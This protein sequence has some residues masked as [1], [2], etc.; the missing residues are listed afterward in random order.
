MKER[1]YSPID[2]GRLSLFRRLLLGWFDEHGRVLPW[3]DIKDPYKIWV[4]EII[5]QQTQVVQG[6]DYYERFVGTYPNVTSLAHAK[7]EDV[8]LLW[9]GLGYYS[10]AHNMLTAARQIEELH[11]GVFPSTEKEVSSLKGIGPYTTAAI[12]SIAYDQPLAVVDGNVYRVLSRVEASVTPIDTS[13]GQKYYR[14]LATEYL[15]TSEPGKYNQAIMDLG[16]LVCTPKNAKCDEC[17]VSSVC[18][19]RGNQDLLSLLPIKEKKTAVENRYLDY[20]LIID[21]E[22]FFIEQRDKAGIWKGLFQL[23]LITS[24]EG[25]ATPE[26][27]DAQLPSGWS[28]VESISLKPHRLTHRLLHIRVHVCYPSVTGA[29]IHHHSYRRIP[30]SEH[31]KL[32][33]PKPLRHFLDTH[34]GK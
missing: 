23:P 31:S 24:N 17:P 25:L 7:D 4:S 18:K 33:F 19:S 1:Q 2:E 8:L 15:D 22:E 32:A 29:T 5:L 27:I 3:R 30:I 16:A 21:G 6:W 11:D 12:M 34:F 28:V 9:Q 14:A 13:K 26:Y 10:R 20:L